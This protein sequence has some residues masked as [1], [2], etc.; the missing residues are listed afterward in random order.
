MIP[1]FICGAPSAVGVCEDCQKVVVHL[2]DLLGLDPNTPT[3]PTDTMRQAVMFARANTAGW[4]E[5]KHIKGNDYLYFRWREGKRVKS[6]YIG[7]LA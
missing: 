3:Y 2:E 1:C 4:F 5:K 7:K 6:R